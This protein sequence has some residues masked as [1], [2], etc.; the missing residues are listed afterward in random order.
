[1]C[2]ARSPPARAVW[3]R[4]FAGFLPFARVGVSMGGVEERPA[5]GF[6]ASGKAMEEARRYRQSLLGFPYAHE[7]LGNRHTAAASRKQA[8]CQGDTCRMASVPVGGGRRRTVPSENPYEILYGNKL[9]MVRW[10]KMSAMLRCV[11]PLK[12]S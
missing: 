6:R 1:M 2:S 8:A 4:F 12:F 9:A 10:R 7:G 11:F 5:K 3:G